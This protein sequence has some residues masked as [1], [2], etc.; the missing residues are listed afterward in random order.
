LG[1][2]IN[3]FLTLLQI[4]RATVPVSARAV[5]ARSPRTFARPASEKKVTECGVVTDCHGTSDQSGVARGVPGPRCPQLF[6]PIWAPWGLLG[7]V[8]GV[9]R[10]GGAENL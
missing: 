8:R 1:G 7:L 5:N 2:R 10:A 6:A 3:A 4:Q 9:R